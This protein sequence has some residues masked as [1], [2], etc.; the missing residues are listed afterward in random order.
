LTNI[1][2]SLLLTL[3]GGL[4]AITGTVTSLRIQAKNAAIARQEQYKRED[5]YR[6][7]DKRQLAYSELYLHVGE[8]RRTLAIL[9]RNKDSREAFQAAREARNQYWSAY[10]VVRLIGSPDVFEAA[11]DLFKWMDESR[12]TR[13][14]DDAS[15]RKFLSRFTEVARSELVQPAG[16]D[17][18]AHSE[19]L[20]R[21]R[22]W[23]GQKLR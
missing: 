4:L 6:L 11:K 8:V 2:A 9:S 3:T 13:E 18:V 12:D 22:R 15:Y 14:F 1:W 7:F 19:T 10:A 5:S 20:S 21:K 23:Y 16:S 17:A